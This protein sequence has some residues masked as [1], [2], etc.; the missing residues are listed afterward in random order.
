[1]SVSTITT[2]VVGDIALI[3]AVSSLLGALARRCGQPAVIGQI[4]TGILLGPSLLGHFPGHLT[5]HLFPV[6]VIPYLSVLAQVA[7]VIF[8]FGVG[9]E[10]DFAAL[11]GRGRALS[12]TASGAMLIPMALGAGLALALP[13]AFTAAGE[14]HI[15]SR[16][17]ILFI[18]VATS[19]TALPVLASIVRERGLAGSTV[20]TLATAVAGFMDVGAWLLLAVAVAGTSG[21]SHRPWY[22]TLAL[23]AAFSALMLAVVRPALR[24]WFGRSG[25]MAA[26]QIPV[27][28]VLAASGAWVTSQLGLHPIFGAFLAGLTLRGPDGKQDADVLRCVDGAATFLLP[29]FFVVTGLSLNISSLNGGN[30]ALL[31]LIILIACAGKVVP[32]YLGAR[33]GGFGSRDSATVAALLNTRGLTELIA[34]SVGLQTGIIHQTLFTMLVLM[35]LVTTV[36][37]APLLSLSRRLPGPGART[38]RVP[39]ELRTGSAG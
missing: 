24:W 19:V 32:A 29:L 33:L 4:I 13:G 28:I 38:G 34:L 12:L 26:T 36:M 10:I 25:A 3:L 23:I 7:V 37:T 27:A 14:S 22:V 11:R 16:S 31:A 8:M 2:F 20:G 35:A 6:Q 5:S 17:F 30:V 9:Y 1:M 18:G 15:T 39:E 21:A